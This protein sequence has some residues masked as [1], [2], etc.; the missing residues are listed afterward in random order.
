M[1]I[2]GLALIWWNKVI[3]ISINFLISQL[4]IDIVRQKT[5][6]CFF[7]SL[8]NWRF[9]T[10]RLLETSTFINFFLLLTV[11]ELRNYS[12]KRWLLKRFEKNQVFYSRD[13]IVLS[14]FIHSGLVSSVWKCE[15]Y[16]DNWEKWGFHHNSQIFRAKHPWGEGRY[17]LLLIIY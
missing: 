4:N 8:K 10:Q 6:H 12:N 13:L 17:N 2:W 1:L 11:A 3:Q 5:F 16:L 15:R 9:R 14:L 7:V